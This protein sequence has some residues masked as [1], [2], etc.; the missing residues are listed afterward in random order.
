MCSRVM[1]RSFDSLDSPTALSGSI[2]T[3][4][5]RTPSQPEASDSW[6]IV[7]LTSGMTPTPTNSR[8][9]AQALSFHL[10]EILL[11]RFK[12]RIAPSRQVVCVL[13]HF[14]VRF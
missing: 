7:T 13:A 10:Q 14:H 2:T 8:R 3:T 1:L 4:S 12:H 5:S 6:V 11:C 9:S